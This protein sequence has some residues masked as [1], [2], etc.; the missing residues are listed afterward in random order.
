MVAFCGGCKLPLP[1]VTARKVAPSE[2]AVAARRACALGSNERREPSKRDPDGGD[3]IVLDD[4]IGRNRELI[5]CAEDQVYWPGRGVM[6]DHEAPE[7]D[8][9]R[10]QDLVE[11]LMFPVRP[12]LVV[13]LQFRPKILHQMILEGRIP[14]YRIAEV[15]DI[16]AGRI[17]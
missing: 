17:A 1:A 13:D 12:I 9:R 2:F 3:P 4:R 14:K 15:R 8:A 10:E 16:H 11:T 5:A 7:Y 6:A